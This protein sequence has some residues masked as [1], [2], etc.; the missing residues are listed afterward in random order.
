MRI[1]ITGNGK[2]GSWKIRGEQLGKA[3]GAVVEPNASDAALAQADVAIFVKKVPPNYRE[4]KAAI[5][6]MVDCYKQPYAGNIKWLCED[7]KARSNGFSATIAATQRMQDDVGATWSLPHHY[8]P[9]IAENQIRA[10]VKRVGYCGDVRYID[11]WLPVVSEECKYRGWEL[12]I[13]PENEADCDILLG[14]RGENWRNYTTD[15]WKS[16]VKFANAVGSLTPFIGLPECGYTEMGVPFRPVLF[17]SDIG[18]AFDV[19]T[20]YKERAK[21]ACAYAS[22]RARFSIDHIAG[23][24]VEWLS[25]RF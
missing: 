21:L 15:N 18:H 1:I 14:L 5:W 16:G 3:I 12:V 11:D 7:L 22:A 2:S 25:S 8:R 10:K 17:H 20:E 4:A 19:M 6:D 23:R 24:Y 9:G 13:N